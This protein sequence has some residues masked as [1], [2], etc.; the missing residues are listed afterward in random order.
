MT[1]MLEENWHTSKQIKHLFTI[2]SIPVL[3]SENHN[4]NYMKMSV[5]KNEVNEF[6]DAKEEMEHLMS[7]PELR[8]KS[9]TPESYYQRIHQERLE[10]KQREEKERRQ[11][12]IQQR[13]KAERAAQ[14]KKAQEE[15]KRREAQIEAGLTILE[16][17][18][19]DGR[20]KVT[21]FKG[22]KN[23]IGQWLKKAN[24][25]TLPED[26][27]ELLINFLNRIYVDI[28]KRERKQWEDFE[29]GV[30][31]DIIKWIGKENAKAIFDKLIQS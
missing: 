19:D 27:H 26:E 4:Y 29:K 24:H 6:E 30:W 13:E 20:Y 18:Y 22:A 1:Q 14:E 11:H 7:Y 31:S 12:E 5:E 25:E 17:K 10:R 9:I 16:E 23:R 15:I 2:A 8:G 3:A 28:N 21:D